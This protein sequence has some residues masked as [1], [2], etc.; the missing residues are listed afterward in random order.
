MPLSPNEKEQLAHAIRETLPELGDPIYPPSNNKIDAFLEKLKAVA[1]H[2]E[3]YII[4]DLRGNQ[5]GIP[6][7]IW[8]EGIDRC[9][10]YDRKEV[11][12]VLFTIDLVHDDYREQFLRFSSAAYHILQ[13]YDER[14]ESLQH[15]YII[16]LPIRKANE[17]YVWVKQMS[18]PLKM[19]ANNMI[20]HQMNCYTIM[21][22]FNGVRLP[23]APRIFDSEGKRRKELEEQIFMQVVDILASQLTKKEK[24]VFLT[25]LK[26]KREANKQ[27]NGQSNGHEVVRDDIAFDLDIALNT[28]RLHMQHIKSKAE[29]F[30]CMVFQDY[31]EA[32]ATMEKFGVDRHLTQT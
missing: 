11:K 27:K 25:Y 23:F 30:F 8:N 13:H 6:S 19:D 18:M 5:N 10:G 3:Y 9:L 4:M 15:R 21:S 26:L 22:G 29:K 24:N 2:D 14:L 17:K 31:H 16:N 12:D 28:A 20:V 1:H 32:F 7:I